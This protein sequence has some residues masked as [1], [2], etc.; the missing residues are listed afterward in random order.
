MFLGALAPD[1]EA[2]SQNNSGANGDDTAG[3][4][5]EDGISFSKLLTS[6]SSNY[7]IA[8]SNITLS[9]T[10]GTIATLHAWIDF[11]K[12]GS[13]EASEYAS[14]TINSGTS[15]GHPTTPLSWTGL[16]GLTTGT[17][18]ARF[19]LTTSSLSDSG[20]TSYDDR[21]LGAALD[22]EV[23]D[24]SLSIVA[25][26][27]GTV[28]KDED[29]NDSFG[30]TDTGVT[31][32]TVKLYKDSNSNGLF[33]ASTDTLIDT[34]VS[35]SGGS[36][37]LGTSGSGTYFVVLDHLDANMPAAYL[38]DRTVRAVSFSGS[39]LSNQ[40][41][42]LD[43]NTTSLASCTVSA[44]LFQNN[45]S[46]VYGLNL[47]TGSSNLLASD[48][49]GIHVNG[50][51]FNPLDNFIYGAS[52]TVTNGSI[53]KVDGNFNVSYLGPI[54]GLPTTSYVVGDISPDGKLFQGLALYL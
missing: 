31:D 42:P 47:A 51:G 12:D 1:S 3:T 30:G 50:I 41:F 40:N 25:G 33:E 35:V 6:S 46:D 49:G 8:T 13:F 20:A 26:I 7:S 16:S 23:E 37:A 43:P 28:F 10:S 9:N 17:T 54:V 15:G 36:F 19:R 44:F 24:Y 38:P 45:P 4:D 11:D 39:S 18:Y 29:S 53:A 48:I 52:N 5:D 14:V 34:D 22:G 32:I 27:S 21:A 2:S